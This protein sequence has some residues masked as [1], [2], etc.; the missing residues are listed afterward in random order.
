MRWVPD[1]ARFF[2]HLAAQGVMILL[3]VAVENPTAIGLVHSAPCREIVWQ[4]PPLTTRPETIENGIDHL[5]SEDTWL[6]TPG[7][8]A[9]FEHRLLEQAPFSIG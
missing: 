2:S 7:R 8:P 4:V 5:S 3:P 1:R 6:T 9:N